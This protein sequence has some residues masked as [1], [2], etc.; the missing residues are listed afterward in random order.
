MFEQ[1]TPVVQDFVG[2]LLAGVL[3]VVSAFLIALVKKGFDWVGAKIDQIADDKARKAL[4]TAR[5]NLEDI[6]T[7]TVTSLQQ[8]LADD[9]KASIAAGDGKYTMD[10]LLGLKDKALTSIK[11][12]LTVSTKE[13]LTTAY[14]DLDAFIG[15]LIE[16]K[17]RE[18]KLGLANVATGLLVSE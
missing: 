16:T 9:I 15:D 2:T 7:S 5:C 18:L 12:Q 11:S 4:D 13:A 10:D 6:V 3:A 1:V 14:N 8:T 17:V